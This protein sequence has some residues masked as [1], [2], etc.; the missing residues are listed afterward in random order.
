MFTAQQL[1][2]IEDNPD[3]DNTPALNDAFRRGG[4]LHFPQ[5]NYFFKSQPDKNPDNG[6]LK[7][8]GE[9]K[10]NTILTRDYVPLSRDDALIWSMRAVYI[11]DLS[12]HAAPNT[13]GGCAIKLRSREASGSV[14]RDLYIT[15]RKEEAG[16]V[17]GDWDTV[18]QL[19]GDTEALGIRS[20]HLENLDLFAATL[21]HLWVVSAHGLR[22]YGVQAYTA[23]GTASSRAVVQGSN[24]GQWLSHDIQFVS[25]YLENLWF[26]STQHAR[27]IGMG[28]TTLH[29]NTTDQPCTNIKSL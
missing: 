27:L 23:G 25:S 4:W 24:Q 10:G 20:C 19:I 8:T 22:C 5:G 29:V 9:G 26:Y 11:S 12:I 15:Y 3:F 1:G 7:I 18:I 14:L 21:R 16:Q 13:N 17:H 6:R 28:N 2:M